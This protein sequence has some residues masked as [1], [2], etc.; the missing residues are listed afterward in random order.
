MLNLILEKIYGWINDGL[1][2]PSICHLNVFEY[3]KEEDETQ[4]KKYIFL[5]TE[6]AG[7]NGLSITNGAEDLMTS[8][9]RNFPEYM[10]A[11][12]QDLIYY[13]YYIKQDYLG[14]SLDK[15]DAQWN[16]KTKKFTEPIKWQS[17]P[18]IDGI[19]LIDTI[20]ENL[21]NG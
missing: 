13:E 11:N 21:N 10:P 7:N 14:E 9:V 16:L 3:Q 8:F 19:N 2:T 20:K 15:V 12:P 18:L 1:I 17:I 4:E 6:A 5:V